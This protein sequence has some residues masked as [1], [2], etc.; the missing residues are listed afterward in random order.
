VS[1][2]CIRPKAATANLTAPW[3]LALQFRATAI[4]T[5]SAANCHRLEILWIA[6]AWDIALT[7]AVRIHFRDL[8]FSSNPLLV[9]E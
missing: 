2:K 6:D 3:P 1:P 5:W 4:R 8:S 7:V 9:V